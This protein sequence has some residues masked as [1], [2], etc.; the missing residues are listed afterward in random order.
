MKHIIT[1]VALFHLDDF[2]GRP[3]WHILLRHNSETHIGFRLD[4]LIWEKCKET[5]DRLNAK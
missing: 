1:S 4:G 5:A 3:R 2:Q